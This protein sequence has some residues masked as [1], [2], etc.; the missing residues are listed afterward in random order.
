M[1]LVSSSHI[2][3]LTSMTI[4]RYAWKFFSLYWPAPVTLCEPTMCPVIVW[5]WR[6]MFPHQIF[7]FH[8]NFQFS[9]WLRRLYILCSNPPQHKG[10]TFFNSKKFV[11]FK[12]NDNKANSLYCITW[13]DRKQMVSPKKLREETV[14]TRYLWCISVAEWI[15]LS[16]K[17]IK[18]S[19]TNFL[20]SYWKD[21]WNSRPISGINWNIIGEMLSLVLTWHTNRKTEMRCEWAVP[22]AQL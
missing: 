1:I 2:C 10:W 9:T 19:L 11:F 17:I 18:S 7:Y 12:D 14:K 13:Q 21:L 22:F 15:L 6:G 20:D 3:V 5:K 8:G 16:L 4:F